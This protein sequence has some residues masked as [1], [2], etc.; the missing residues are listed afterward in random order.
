MAVVQVNGLLRVDSVMRSASLEREKQIRDCVRNKPEWIVI[1]A[2]F[3]V[4]KM[5]EGMRKCWK[6]RI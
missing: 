4:I 5:N 3:P 1:I 6:I 2:G